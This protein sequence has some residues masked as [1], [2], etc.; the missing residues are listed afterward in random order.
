MLRSVTGAAMEKPV[1]LSA[2]AILLFAGTVLA[3]DHH[4]C[5]HLAWGMVSDGSLRSIAEQLPGAAISLVISL[6][7]AEKYFRRQRDIDKKK[8][9]Q[10][11]K[12]HY[13]KAVNAY[14]TFLGKRA[15]YPFYL[16]EA[17]SD[18]EITLNIYR[19]DFDFNQLRCEVAELAKKTIQER[20]DDFE[21]ATPE[22]KN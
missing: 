19:T 8:E 2:L 6:L 22:A 5:R 16:R 9:E 17:L 3:Q 1:V 10:D 18:L 13:R 11:V 4:P 12:L 20:P 15:K 21:D 14:I 7:I